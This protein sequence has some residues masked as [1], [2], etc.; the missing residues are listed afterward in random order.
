MPEVSLGAF[1]HEPCDIAF[2]N[3][4][5]RL[6]G[7][8]LVQ[9]WHAEGFPIDIPNFI[10]WKHVFARL[11]LHSDAENDSSGGCIVVCI[12]CCL[13]G[14]VTCCQVACLTRCLVA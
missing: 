9:A 5:I 1:L 14:C 11:T 10:L 7:L 8:L 2:I 4:S 6:L 12:T 13:M 3:R